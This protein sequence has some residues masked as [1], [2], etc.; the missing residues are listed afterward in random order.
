MKDHFLDLFSTRSLVPHPCGYGIYCD[1]VKGGK[2]DKER[3][4]KHT[5]LKILCWYCVGCEEVEISLH[6]DHPEIFYESTALP[7]FFFF[8]LCLVALKR[9]KPISCVLVNPTTIVSQQQ[10]SNP[11][12]ERHPK[13]SRKVNS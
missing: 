5:G 10:I 9:N 13:W 11:F 8:F 6:Y 1:L 3:H 4:R 2:A 12:L 7:V